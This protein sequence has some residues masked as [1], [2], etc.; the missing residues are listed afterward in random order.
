M[1]SRCARKI[2][3]SLGAT[4]RNANGEG[5]IER[6]PSLGFSSR[7]IEPTEMRQSGGEPE[8]C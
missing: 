6:K 4:V 5:R 1:R 3:L 8:M 2:G 7:L